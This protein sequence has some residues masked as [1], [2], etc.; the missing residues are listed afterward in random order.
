M[1]YE[2]HIARPISEAAAAALPK[3]DPLAATARYRELKA[4]VAFSL[5]EWIAAVCR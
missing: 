1:P 4:E 2:I 5:N 3:G